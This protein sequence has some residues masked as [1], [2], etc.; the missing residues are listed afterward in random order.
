MTDAVARAL[1]LWDLPDAT[2][3]HFAHRENTIYRVKSGCKTYAMR[4]HRPG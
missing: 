1:G 2:C 3:E 4:V